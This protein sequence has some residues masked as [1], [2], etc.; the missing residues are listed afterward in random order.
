M[1]S[2]ITEH[3]V[4]YVIKVED[5]CLDFIPRFACFLCGREKTLGIVAL[6]NK[7]RQFASLYEDQMSLAVLAHR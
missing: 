3:T 6:T 5:G 2:L 4:S 7:L 1:S